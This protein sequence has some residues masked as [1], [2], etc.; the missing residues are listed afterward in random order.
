MGLW[1]TIKDVLTKSPL[2]EARDERRAEREA[3]KANDDVPEMP[4]QA[5]APAPVP[6][7]AGAPAPSEPAEEGGKADEAEPEYRSN[8]VK[9]GDTLSEIAQ[10]YGVDWREMAELNNLENPDLIFPGQVFKV[11]NN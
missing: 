1:T 9:S 5:P 7:S 11:P 3:G 8:T 4:Q 6:D 2:D 10:S